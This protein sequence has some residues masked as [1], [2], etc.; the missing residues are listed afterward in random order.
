MTEAAAVLA[1]V[2][3]AVQQLLVREPFYAHVLMRM[4]RDVAD[5]V[6]TAA[7]T[8]RDG[9]VTL[10]VNPGF[11]LREL[12]EER[13]RV[14]VLK[15]EVLHV[16]LQ[17]LFRARAGM[18]RDRLNVAADLA[19]NCH[20]GLDDLPAG[21]LRI[22]HPVLLAESD[23]QWGRTLEWYYERLAAGPSGEAL[24]SLGRSG[25]QGAEWWGEGCTAEG[26]SVAR[27]TIRRAASAVGARTLAR[28]P[29][30][31][32]EAVRSAGESDAARIDWRR[33]VRL[34]GASSRRTQIRNTLKRPSKRFGRIPG[35]KVQSRSHVVVAVDT[36]GSIGREQLEDFFAEVRGIWRA[37]AEVTV[38]ECDD[39][40]RKVWPFRGAAPER[41]GGGG[42]TDFD[43]VIRW[44]NEHGARVDGLIYLTDGF[45]NRSV[46]CRRRV[47]WVVGGDRHSI[48]AMRERIRPTELVV[49]LL[50]TGG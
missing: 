1:S 19:V 16:V 5:E 37:G 22:D 34:F 32:Q 48:E 36:S 7:V 23:R 11:W 38:I 15:H 50:T 17:H 49:E 28:L 12:S 4:R 20:I 25:G 41:C 9:A 33:A 21:A 47:L 46:A 43:P 8:V 29:G 26:V 44:V 13:H 24:A 31:V 42:G 40:V 18:D 2:A 35:V 27:E 30:A 6:E 10:L 14:G 3:A 45:G 39:E